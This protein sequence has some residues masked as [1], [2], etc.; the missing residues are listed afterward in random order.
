MFKGATNHPYIT[1]ATLLGLV[2]VGG[3][4][5]DVALRGKESLAAKG[6]NLVFPAKKDVMTSESGVNAPEAIKDAA[7]N[8]TEEESV[9]QVTTQEEVVAKIVEKAK[10]NAKTE[11]GVKTR[12]QRRAEVENSSEGK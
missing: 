5:L 12:S 10:E 6:Y 2:L 7:T 9:Q 4:T 3:E 11:T 8:A 1:V